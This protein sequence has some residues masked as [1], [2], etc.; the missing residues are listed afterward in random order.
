LTKIWTITKWDVFFETQCIFHLTQCLPLHY[1]EKTEPTKHELKW[2]ETHQKSIANIINCDSKKDWQ[3]WIIFG[4]NI[5]DATWHQMIILVPTSPNVCFC[6]TWENPIRW[7]KTKT[8]YFID[9]V[10]PSSAETNNG[11][12]RKLESHLIASC[13]RNIGVKNYKNL[14]NLL[15]ITIENVWDVFLWTRYISHKS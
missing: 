13:V 4:A 11:C 14:I 3:I 6:T 5:S 1:L 2:T 10:S 9:S 7:N 12:R 8:Q 15:Q